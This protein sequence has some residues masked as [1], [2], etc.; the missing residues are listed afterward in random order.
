VGGIVVVGCGEGAA[1]S[2]ANFLLLG[3]WLR[4]KRV[5]LKPACKRRLKVCAGAPILDAELSKKHPVDSVFTQVLA[6]L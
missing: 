1:Q 6:I 4:A 2:L 5:G 3:R